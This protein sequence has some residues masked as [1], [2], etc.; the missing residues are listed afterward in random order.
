MYRPTFTIQLLLKFPGVEKWQSFLPVC[1]FRTSRIYKCGTPHRSRFITLPFCFRLNVS[2]KWFSAYPP[3]IVFI[4]LN[5]QPKITLPIYIRMCIKCILDRLGP[6]QIQ[7]GVIRPEW[8]VNTEK[9]VSVA[10]D[11]LTVQNFFV[12]ILN[13]IVIKQITRIFVLYVYDMHLI[14]REAVADLTVV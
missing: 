1:Q 12:S 5:K 8:P 6:G 3:R 10:H 9:C 7:R 2:P 11:T 13:T 14:W 4:M